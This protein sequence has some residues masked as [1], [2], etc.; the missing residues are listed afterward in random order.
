MN[1]LTQWGIANGVTARGMADLRTLLCA[2]AVLP[3]TDSAAKSEAATT[4]SLRLACSKIGIVT[5]RN[6]V[7]VFDNPNGR[8][9]RCGLW[10]ESAQMNKTLKSGDVVGVSP[11]LIAQEHVGS[12]LGQFFMREMKRSD[13]RYTGTEREE[14]QKR[15]IEMI[16]S[17][18]GDAAF[19]VGAI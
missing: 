13:W 14:A 2:P 1:G 7:G 19:S 6:N 8:P 16:N 4:V 3:G 9:V 11:V 18:G 12:T 15:C 10:N 5:T 17:L